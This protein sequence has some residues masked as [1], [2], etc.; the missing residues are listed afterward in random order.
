MKLIRLLVGLLMINIVLTAC[1][2]N[3]IQ[4]NATNKTEIVV[5]A[6]ASLTEV[7]EELKSAYEEIHPEVRIIYNFAGSQ[8]LTNQ[9]T[10][11]ARPAMFFSANE[12]YVD[13]LI[14][15]GINPYD[16]KGYTGIKDLFASNRLVV[17]YGEKNEF[18][19]LEEVVLALDDERYQ[20]VILAQEEVPVGKY[21]RK[22]LVK[23]LEKTGDEE[24]YNAFYKQVV[25]YESDVKAVVAKVRIGEGDIGVVYKTDAKS[26]NLEEDKLAYFDVEDA[27][28]Q[29]ATY[30]GLLFSDLEYESDFYEFIVSGEGQTILR[31]AGF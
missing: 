22:M 6:A 20:P 19:S 10:S 18:K 17:L 26:L 13:Q 1:H 25:S 15:E 21:T 12:G 7:M 11:G 24:G 31:E 16:V 3:K 27:Y 2:E 8:V 9:I 14:E 29:V 28:N 5:F 23:Y 4:D 30:G